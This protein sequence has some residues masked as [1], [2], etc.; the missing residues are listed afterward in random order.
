MPRYVI[1]RHELPGS[2]RGG[3]HWDFM[4]EHGPMLRTWALSEEPSAGQEI[5]ADVLVDHRPFYLDYEGPIS[6]DRG[7]VSRWD[8]GEYELVSDT[9]VNVVTQLRGTRLTGLA[10]LRTDSVGSHRWIFEFS[11]AAADG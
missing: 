9:P 2:Q 3:V 1:L 10:A 6:G 11:A 8:A 5:R 7:T 4:L